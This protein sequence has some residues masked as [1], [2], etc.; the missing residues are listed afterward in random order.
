MTIRDA[1]LLFVALTTIAA[2]FAASASTL[3]V[4][5]SAGIDATGCGEIG[6]PPSPAC[7]TIQF[8]VGEAA[9]GDTI[10]VRA[11]TYHECVDLRG[12][13]V[14]LRADA[15]DPSDPD[16][17]ALTTIDGA[18]VCDIASGNSN[19]AV[20]VGDGSALTGFTVQ[21][22][23]RSGVQGFGAAVITQN[24]IT[25]NSGDRG[26]GVFAYSA[27]YYDGS[28]PLLV[29][30]NDVTGNVATNSGGGIYAYARADYGLPGRPVEIQGNTV[31][32][33]TTNGSPGRGSGIL[34][35]TQS[36]PGGQAHVVVTQNII[37]GNTVAAPGS[38]YG[39]SGYGG[40]LF[41]A[42]YYYGSDLIEITNNTVRN[43]RSA[44]AGGGL[45]LFT[46][47]YSYYYGYG[48]PEASA[49]IVVSGNTVEANTA[50]DPENG[51]GHG[52]G[53]WAQ[54][55]GASHESIEI[56]S[57]QVHDNVAQN[58]GGGISAW[59]TP[60]SAGDQ[61]IL[62]DANVVSGNDAEAGGGLDLQLQLDN[63]PFESRG[64]LLASGN[65]ISGNEATGFEGGGGVL[66]AARFVATVAPDVT[67]E[68]SGNKIIGNSAAWAG[69]G[70]L[71]EV[72]ADEQ[73]DETAFGAAP[74]ASQLVFSNN[75]VADN[76]AVDPQDG[77]AT[78]GGVFAY[79]E[80]RGNVTA[81][82]ALGLNTITGNTADA[83]SAGL[84]IESYTESIGGTDGTARVTLASSIVASNAGTG[85]GGP[86]PGAKGRITAGGSG[87]LLV[88]IDHSDLFDNQE[89][90][91]PW[92]GDR[93]GTSG[94]ISADPG[95]LAGPPGGDYRLVD[96]S[97]CVDA[98][99]NAV[100]PLPITDLDGKARLRDGNFDGT[101]IV[102]MGAYEL[103]ACHE[104]ADCDDGDPCT[105][106]ACVVPTGCAH[107]P[108]TAGTSCEDGNACTSDDACDEAGRCVAGAPAVEGTPC[109]DGNACTADDTCDAAGL[110]VTGP[111]A[112]EGTPCEDGNACTV[113]TT[114]DPNGQCSGGMPLDCDD[115]D[116]C[117]LDLC[118]G[119]WGCLHA[120]TT[121][122]DGDGICSPPDNCPFVSNA[123]QIDADADGV[124]DACDD[125][126]TLYNPGQADAD[127]DEIGDA[128]APVRVDFA[129]PESGAAEGFLLDT[130]SS[131]E[132]LTGHGW[133][134]PVP[135]RERV[136]ADPL[137]LRTF[138]FSMA[139]RRWTREL[140]PGDYDV[141]VVCGDSS[142]P[143]GPHRVIANG[144]GVVEDVSTARGEF[145]ER[146]ARVAV[147]NG[148]L[149]LRIG[150][151]NA[152]TTIDYVEAVLA[153]GQPEEGVP[154]PTVL[155][156]FNF[157]P[158][159]SPVPL[160]FR[161][162]HGAP[163]DPAPGVG[164]STPVETVEQGAPV[165]QVLDTFARSSETAEWNLVVPAAGFYEV[166][167]SVGDPSSA[168]GPHR[169]VVEGL[170]VVLSETTAPGAF[171]ERHAGGYVA[172]GLLT[173]EIGGG[174][175]PT[176][177]NYVV[178]A[179]APPDADGDGILNESDNCPLASNPEQ[180]DA[181]QD[182]LGDPCD[183]DRDGD[184]VENPADNCPDVANAEQSDLDGDRIGDACDACPIEVFNDQDGD[185]VC[186]FADNCPFTY[187]PD[188]EDSNGDGV[189]DDCAMLRVNFGPAG[190]PVP[191]GFLA[192]DGSPFS[193]FRRMGWDQRVGTRERFSS[194]PVEL[195]TLA[196]SLAERNWTAEW[197]NGD[198]LVHLS[199]GDAALAQGPQRVLV[200]GS[201]AF[202][203][204]PVTVRGEFRDATVPVSI[205]DG[206]L[207]LILGGTVA[208]ST[209]N[210]VEA[211]AADP[212]PVLWSIHFQPSDA[213][214]APGF[215]VD[216]GDPFDAG[217]GWG[218]NAPVH[219]RERAA[220]VPHLLDAFAFTSVARTWELSLPA[221]L[222]DV[223]VSV[224]D[225]RHAQGPQRLVV[226]GQTLVD[227]ESTAARQF[228]ERRTQV[229]VEDGRLTIGAG[230]GVGNTCLNYVVV[231]PAQVTP[232]KN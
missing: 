59:L 161:P 91:A 185:T 157:Q 43:N 173:I 79:L 220:A 50:A 65:E 210:F 168:A 38:G 8:A 119:T 104:D 4:D 97:P 198:Y 102:D 155:R 78:G 1:R 194:F 86:D 145:V 231:S 160:G 3:Y 115:G 167:L 118:H 60:T 129:T 66:A 52:G 10:L 108:A 49:R 133:D 46:H 107:A 44:G 126:P 201:P 39:R 57:N 197:P 169:V 124:G 110:C 188:Q 71:L 132:P 73:G 70:A 105:S 156:S 87:H 18:G 142:Y 85:V 29:S 11:G 63:Q 22:A 13:Q 216:A 83:G 187:N 175:G 143:Q 208:N 80:S 19:P 31:R 68:L 17:R 134:F 123:D 190:A 25:G 27:D 93:T 159:G 135:T 45:G 203:E 178:V 116:P 23:G 172:D 229:L 122:E 207:H 158:E 136:S 24:V 67:L 165:P 64:R 171:L 144:Q 214:R 179:Q 88:D 72:V 163:F 204:D 180:E 166:W 125:C 140:P 226:E 137:E 130:G 128:C 222:Y 26:G 55:V 89:E 217:R 120:P 74:D 62:V 146:T 106:D 7:Q 33:N 195:D 113:D 34:V 53:I 202:A 51:L 230:G 76:Q 47:S 205:R 58:R 54:S 69:G 103:Q 191:I 56:L 164:W 36:L 228:L 95:F 30:G 14:V 5:A 21:G 92:I 225:A 37:E 90:Y 99:N 35:K 189:G 127:G 82:A 150:R 16:T 40:G 12:K 186:G 181:D 112:L 77:L 6:A 121:D 152:N 61:R 162:D 223:W 176:T 177:L 212:Q 174:G 139:E 20:Y 141:H 209:L 94:N 147:R 221:G 182:T 114:C 154:V 183:P 100:A 28:A 111:P 215:A 41:A 151:G 15:F 148:R 227:D 2:P 193:P 32:A 232:G 192:D 9:S 218:W 81:W 131:F 149:D 109:E 101:A 170:P 206:R 200:Q 75:L 199:I 211:T 219:T 153:T 117:T 98:G 138:A 184:G 42:S 224:G 84:E 213:V 48:Y 196:F 96:G